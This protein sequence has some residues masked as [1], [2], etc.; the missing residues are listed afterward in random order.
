MV[1][2]WLVCELNQSYTA[3]ST[4]LQLQLRIFLVDDG[5]SCNAEKR[6]YL[7]FIDIETAFFGTSYFSEASLFAIYFSIWRMIS[8][9]RIYFL[10]F[11][12]Q[13]TS[14][15]I[16]TESKQSS[17]NVVYSKKG[18]TFLFE[19][20]ALNS[21][22]CEIVIVLNPL[23]VSHFEIHILNLL[24][25]LIREILLYFRNVLCNHFELQNA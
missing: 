12:S 17:L 14:L 1:V 2:C 3:L 13:Q 15:S 9:L 24:G 16:T 20:C 18:S 19:P 6:F 8:P 21:N 4:S 5:V 11:F 10:A 22:C 25:V 23:G 7:F